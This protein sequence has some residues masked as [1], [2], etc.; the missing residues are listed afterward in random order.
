MQRFYSVKSKYYLP[1]AQSV[2]EYSWFVYNRSVSVS[3]YEPVLQG[4]GQ[5]DTAQ[6][7]LTQAPQRL[8]EE[9]FTLE[10]ACQLQALLATVLNE[11]A[12][13]AQVTT[14]VEEVALPFILEYKNCPLR[15]TYQKRGEYVDPNDFAELE[16]NNLNFMVAAAIRWETH[17]VAEDFLCNLSSARLAELRRMH[18]ENN[19]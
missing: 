6:R 8:A 10:E 9:L 4:Q 5:P 3:A 7:V 15:E 19:G 1:Q 18:R 17:Y 2:V 16:C 13:G 11:V 14:T 12:T